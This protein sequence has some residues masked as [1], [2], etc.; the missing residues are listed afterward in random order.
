MQKS[1]AK[2]LP[3]DTLCFKNKINFKSQTNAEECTIHIYT[4]VYYKTS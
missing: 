1:L 2:F 3:Q 4:N